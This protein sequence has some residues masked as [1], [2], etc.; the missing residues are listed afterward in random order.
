MSACC[1]NL[2]EPICCF[3]CF[4]YGLPLR[5]SLPDKF[6]EWLRT[7]VTKALEFDLL[8]KR[9]AEKVYFFGLWLGSFDFLQFAYARLLL[10]LNFD[11]AR[12]TSVLDDPTPFPENRSELEDV[13]TKALHDAILMHNVPLVERL[14]KHPLT[15]KDGVYGGRSALEV[16][17]R[18]FRIG[19]YVEIVLVLVAAGCNVNFL[20]NQDKIMRACREPAQTRLLL[21]IGADILQK[22]RERGLNVFHWTAFSFND[23]S[24]A[25]AIIEYFRSIESRDPSARTRLQQGLDAWCNEGQ[26]PLIVAIR[27]R[28]PRS[29]KFLIDSGANI[30]KRDGAGATPFD[31]LLRNGRAPHRI[32][33]GWWLFER[34]QELEMQRA[35]L[36]SRPEDGTGD[37]DWFDLVGFLR[38]LYQH[39]YDLF[40]LFQNF[41]PEFE[42]PAID[43]ERELRDSDSDELFGLVVVP[44]ETD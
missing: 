10:R 28:N 17:F 20:D 25:K 40:N 44:S 30:L 11:E 14:I 34:L 35:F 9:H 19:Q 22:N 23:H 16:A 12:T 5:E 31:H 36:H 37:A 7:I 4:G 15:K 33:M 6:V 24:G 43:V 42:G 29:V 21:K 1:P 8:P 38:Q 32:V 18:N 26:T 27:S 39:H 3:G 2:A 13:V 41:F